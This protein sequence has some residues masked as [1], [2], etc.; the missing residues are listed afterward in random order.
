[1]EEFTTPI[2]L[3]DGTVLFSI[4]HDITE[5]KHAEQEVLESKEKLR[6][7][8]GRLERVKEEE[9]IYL[10]R[11]LHDHLGQNLTGLKM[12]IAYLAKKIQTGTS[13]EPKDFLSKTSG[14]I[15]LIDELI[16]N[17]RRISAE[18]RPN[19]LDY[20]G[21]IPAIEW[22]MEELKKRT[23]MDCEF[24]SNVTKV[25]LG[26]QVNSSIF[27]I[28]QE[29]VTNI[30]RHS[31][32]TKVLVS[33]EEEKDIIKFEIL[34][35]GIGIKE[36]DISNARSLGILGM[37]ERTFQFNGKLHLENAPEGGTLLT[38][39]VPKSENK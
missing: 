15:V 23:T 13:I 14:M 7:L 34:D 5:R 35:N 8:T 2:K 30:I 38:L 4:I 18:L 17:V 21:L 27:R 26:S 22:Q 12:D 1:V 29:A 36:E 32:A 28:L 24:K 31:G 10:S 3:K 33:I 9:R 11:E 16:N 39:I 20:L 6:A 25:D 19:V 37:K